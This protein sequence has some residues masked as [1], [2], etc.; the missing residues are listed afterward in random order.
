VVVQKRGSLP[1]FFGRSSISAEGEFLAEE[2]WNCDGQS[3]NKES[4]HNR[5]GEDPL[6]CYNLSQELCDTKSGSQDAKLKSHC[7]VLEGDQ[8]EAPK[9]Q[10]TPDGNIS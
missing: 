10:D 8:E 4:R 1:I 3:S 5:K 6:E 7:I 2:A 9:D